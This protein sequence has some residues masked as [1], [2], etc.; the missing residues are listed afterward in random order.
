MKE[1][2]DYVGRS[3]PIHDALGK[4]TGG[5][6]YAGDMKFP[7]MLH[8]KL[9]LSPIA[10]GIIKEIDTQKAEE[11]PGVVKV[12]SYKNSPSTSF[13]RYRLLP[14]Q[15]NCP[16]DQVLFPRKVRYYGDWVAV[17][18][19]EDAD[20]AQ[21]GIKLIDV[22]YEELPAVTD[23]SDALESETKIHETGNLIHQY[24]Y[25]IGDGD[26]DGED[27]EGNQV[28]LESTVRTPKTHHATMETHVC[29]AQYDFSGKI[30]IW[31]SCQG[32]FAVRT[33]VAD[34]LGLSY[35]K[36]RVIK[37][38]VGGSFGGKQEAILE[39]L[40]AFLAKETRS[41]VMLKLNRKECI[42]STMTRPE[43][44]TRLRTTCSPD[45]K[46]LKCDIDA[47][48]DAGAYAT[49]AM[50]YIGGTMGKIAKLYRIPH[51]NY[52]AKS[53]YTNCPVSG[54]M[55]GWGSPEFFTAV[56][57][58]MDQI[59]KKLKMDPVTFRLQ[60]LVHPYDMDPVSKISLGNAGI[61]ECLEKGAAEFDWYGRY[62][63]SSGTGRFRI[64]VG[65]ACAA[66]KTS[67]YGGGPEFSTM[68]LKMNEDGTFVL[69]TAVQDLGCGSVQSLRIIA[70]EALGIDPEQILVLEAD[71]DSSPYDF[72]SYGTRVT[73]VCGVC[74]LKVAN[75]VRDQ[76][77]D[78]A[79]RTLQVP[80]QYLKI[81]NGQVCYMK[82]KKLHLSFKEIGI[83]SK[84][85]Y[86]L[87]I[88]AT[89]TYHGV[90]N[91]GA[92]GAH[93]A[94][95]KVDRSTGLVKVTDYLAVH[96]I[97]QVINRSMCEGQVQGAVQ[98]GIGYALCEEIALNARGQVINDSLKNYHVINAPD[99]PKVRVLLLERGGDDGPFGAKGIGEV[100]VVPVAAAVVNAVN[101]A[102]GTDLSLLP[103]TPKKIVMA[104]R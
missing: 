77:L 35:N 54:A 80:K 15:E 68:T 69:N 83:I 93:F 14:E 7:G 39:P 57:V 59:A 21:E 4:V 61:I 56:E 10:H 96:D 31:S 40:A 99:M 17:V 49:N 88:I 78:V 52:Q 12:F 81:Q 28:I 65:F 92:Y 43:V 16:A 37:T 48:L 9:L 70:G 103:L 101:H 47:V 3:Y 67:M 5:L 63:G 26:Q 58:Q 34:F 85:K 50:D 64:G 36:V 51:V 79:S 94:E 25:T 13:S 89:E 11:L 53:V 8:A 45:G 104:I 33:I 91:P 29:V 24:G 62:P 66:H 73:Y 60:N 30:T 74:T 18:V 82:D 2:F 32:A 22:K 84:N 76:I 98:M 41:T 27:A 71:T 23:L 95:V 46:L 90:S 72:G 102:L 86:H 55:R 100:A 19:A 44:E 42:L 75:R 1:N 87:D 6:V 38:P 20:I 97:G